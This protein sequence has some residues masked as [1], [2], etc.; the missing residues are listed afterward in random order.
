MAVLTET[1]P[2]AGQLALAQLLADGGTRANRGVTQVEAA[3]STS[4]QC[5]AA[6]QARI[7]ARVPLAIAPSA[8]LPERNMAAAHDDFGKPLLI[9]RD[10]GGATHVFLDVCRHRGTRS[11]FAT[12]TC[13]ARARTTW[14][15]TGSR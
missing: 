5:H 12:C 15:R 6:E 2:R 9:A 7:F 8:L 3:A 14:R 13:S 4:P 1:R 10:A 11:G